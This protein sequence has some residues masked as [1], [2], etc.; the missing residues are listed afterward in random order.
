MRTTIDA[1]YIKR[2]G[3]KINISFVLYI[4]L[5]QSQTAT[6]TPSLFKHGIFTLIATHFILVYLNKTN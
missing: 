1:L 4:F 5:S 3:K 2:D 6:V